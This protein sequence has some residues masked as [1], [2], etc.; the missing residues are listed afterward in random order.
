MS[1]YS[2]AGVEINN[3]KNFFLRPDGTKKRFSED[4]THDAVWKA[5]SAWASDASTVSLI[6]D[7]IFPFPGVNLRDIQS[8]LAAVTP[9]ASFS[10]WGLDLKPGADHKAR[11]K[12]S[13]RPFWGS[14][15]FNQMDSSDR[16]FIRDAWHLLLPNAGGALDFDMAFLR[17]WLKN[18]MKE[19]PDN[20]FSNRR[21]KYS[22]VLT[23]ISERTGLSKEAVLKIV[24]GT[25]QSFEIIAAAADP[26]P[27]WRNMLARA[28]CMLRIALVSVQ[29]HIKSAG[30]CPSVVEWT[31]R[32][33]RHA[34][35]WTRE[36]GVS[37]TDYVADY[38]N[39]VRDFTWGDP[40]PKGI[41]SSPARCAGSALIMRPDACLVWAGPA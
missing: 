39:A 38:E 4:R 23:F 31:E 16:D 17:Y 32:W 34:G 37:R 24:Q 33:F 21:T 30:G 40:L 7:N 22:A 36:S 10:G 1:I 29:Y 13:Y 20:S 3:G 15:P 14:E 27:T 41:W 5:W 18:A 25:R 2:G 35:L 9:G 8:Q 6:E 26:S 19:L 12:R 28:V 11:N